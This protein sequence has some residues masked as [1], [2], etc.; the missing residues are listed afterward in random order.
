MQT[1]GVLLHHEERFEEARGMLAESRI[2]LQDCGDLNCWA[3]STRG[4]NQADLSLGRYREPAARTVEV[5]DHLPILPLTE[6]HIPRTLDLCARI[7]LETG[8]HEQAA[9]A[10]GKAAD[11]PLPGDTIFGREE[12]QDPVRSGLEASIGPE[13]MAR[14]G[15][16]GAALDTGA[17]L[18]RFRGWLLEVAESH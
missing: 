13:E 10:F 1:L 17:A 9:I 5:I 6:Y 2:L 14:L 7:L 18:D 11:V 8:R 16:E 12:N 4:M 15:A 3:N